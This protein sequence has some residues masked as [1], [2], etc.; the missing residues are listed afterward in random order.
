MAFGRAVD[1]TWFGLFPMIWSEHSSDH[2]SRIGISMIL[3][4][5]YPGDGK[6]SS[7]AT[8]ACVFSLTQALEQQQ[9]QQ[10]QQQQQ[11]QQQSNT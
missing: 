8:V 2:W 4:F 1:K 5:L 3:G 10:K 6:Y 7:G 9:Q 11:Q